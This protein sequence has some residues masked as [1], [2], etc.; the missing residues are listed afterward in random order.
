MLDSEGREE[1]PASKAGRLSILS[2][3]FW[4]K[5]FAILVIAP[6]CL[7]A[8][9]ELALRAF[10]Y[11]RPLRLFTTR[12]FG[13]EKF[14]VRNRAFYE[15]LFDNESGGDLLVDW[16]RFELLVPAQKRPNA[17]RIFVFGGSAAYGQPDPAYS[18]GRFL[19]VMLRAR[20]PDTRFEVYPLGFR[21][22]N[23]HV[24]WASARACRELEPDL[25]VVYMGNNEF[26]NHL[27]SAA[28]PAPFYPHTGLMHL[29]MVVSE[30]R[31][32]QFIRKASGTLSSISPWKAEEPALGF[33]DFLRP[34]DPS[35]YAC[36][37]ANLEGICQYGFGA[38]AKVA[39]CTVA[40]NLRHWPPLAS[41]HRQ[42]LSPRD[43]AQWDAQ[44]EAGVE[45]ETSA[46]WAEAAGAYEKA[47]LLD[48]AYAELQFRLGRCYWRLGDYEAARGCFTSA[49]ELDWL[50]WRADDRLNTTVRE[51][52]AE[53]APQGAL[54]V[55]TVRYLEERSPHQ[56]PGIEF[57][58]DLCHMTV[59]CRYHVARAI[60][61][62]V[63]PVLPNWIRNRATGDLEALSQSECQ[64]RLGLDGVVLEEIVA[65][66]LADISYAEHCEL[67][68]GEIVPEFTKRLE[69]CRREIASGSM[70]G[71]KEEVYKVALSFAPED[72][73]LRYGLADNVL[74]EGSVEE[75]LDECRRLVRD[76][77][78]L[79]GSHRLWATALLRAQRMDE[80]TAA[81][82]KLTELY[83]DHWLA[84]HLLGALLR[85]AGR[86]REA[87]AAERKAADIFPELAKVQRGEPGLPEK[88]FDKTAIGFAS[89]CA[90]LVDPTQTEQCDRIDVCF[91]AIDPQLRASVWERMVGFRPRCAQFHYR[92][93]KV[94][95]DGGD[96]EQALAAYQEAAAIDAQY[97]AS[98]AWLRS[99]MGADAT[100]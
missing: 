68:Q 74:F 36:F 37:K 56:C 80:A 39:L 16:G 94:H 64:R 25:F 84:Y 91:D 10:G 86:F 19:E 63:V 38:G 89:V 18:F 23:S 44:F 69:E 95:Q 47:A 98:V 65:R 73:T 41:K 76:F 55:D 14:A 21:A 42:D 31:L 9:S 93:G 99:Q 88:F 17:Y 48:D 78:Y 82:R 53:L 92:L 40:T 12:E 71:K 35:M 24:M 20:F 79:A 96:F 77:P 29:S 87:A 11:G 57:F 26:H 67:G 28:R 83:P 70:P 4:A 97:R 100:E 49:R 75:A 33:E 22:A 7:L 90:L 81:L 52:A 6:V 58:Y 54:L 32:V 66:M 5:W 15:Y 59:E 45:F 13:G 61:E 62:Q 3:R 50:R 72:Y 60:F 46:N 8:A 27:N 34:R 51:T 85:K 1:T 2:W 43:L 30:M